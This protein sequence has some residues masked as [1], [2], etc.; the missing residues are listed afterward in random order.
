MHEYTVTWVID[1]S[2]D[3]PEEAARKAR[4]MLLNPESVADVFEVFETGGDGRV[5]DVDLSELDGRPVN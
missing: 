5:T 3:D 1:I 2:A 4:A